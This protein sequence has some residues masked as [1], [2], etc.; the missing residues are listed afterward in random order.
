VDGDFVTHFGTKTKQN[1]TRKLSCQV[2][3][4]AVTTSE[5]QPALLILIQITTGKMNPFLSFLTAR[6]SFFSDKWRVKDNRQNFRIP[7]TSFA[8]CHHLL[9]EPSSCFH[10]CDEVLFL[11]AGDIQIHVH[12]H[13]SPNIFRY[14]KWGNPNLYKLYVDT[15]YGYRSF[16]TAQIAAQS[17]QDSS[18]LGTWN[19]WSTPEN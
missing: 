6:S 12:E 9:A 11:F 15:A 2:F 10:R 3:I 13:D 19:F 1:Y 18:F 5:H 4:W 16:P 7:V 14:L 17:V 8:F